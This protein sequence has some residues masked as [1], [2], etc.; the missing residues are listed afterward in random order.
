MADEKQ[1]KQ[2]KVVFGLLCDM[3]DEDEWHYD[4]DEERL[5]I[6]CSAR[7]EDLP[8][9]I[10]LQVDP[11]RYLVSLY[12]Q[13]PYKVSEEKRT[14]LAIATCIANDA[15]ADGSFDYN[16]FKGVIIFRMTNSYRESLISKELLKYMVY[17]ACNTV[18]TYN[19]K[20]FMISKG[21]LSLEDFM[22]KDDN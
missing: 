2:A 9:Q 18:D 19:D 13:M 14:E 11:A 7:G 21:A 17:I 5:S 8:I 10:Y 4:K 1:I 16:I 12:S 20:F 22:K 15:L 6:T 3:L